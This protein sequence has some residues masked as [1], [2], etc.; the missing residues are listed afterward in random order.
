MKGQRHACEYV[1]EVDSSS[2]DIVLLRFAPYITVLSC[3]STLRSRDSPRQLSF[4]LL[5]AKKSIFFP[6]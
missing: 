2:M 4:M 3:R 1:I 6:R 5:V